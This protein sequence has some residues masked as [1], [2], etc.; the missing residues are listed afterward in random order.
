MRYEQTISDLSKPDPYL[1]VAFS[2][3]YPDNF[4]VGSNS[5]IPFQIKFNRMITRYFYTFLWKSIRSEN[6]VLLLCG[7]SISKRPT[8]SVKSSN[9]HR[10]VIIVMTRPRQ[11]LEERL[12]SLFLVTIGFNH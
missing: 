7:M 10:L 9:T 11:V 1:V 12:S 2:V 6:G 5:S 8:I 4:Q 3:R